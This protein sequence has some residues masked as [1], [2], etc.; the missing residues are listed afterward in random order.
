MARVDVAAVIIVVVVVVV[1]VAVVIIVC[2]C[3]GRGVASRI[4][5][6]PLLFIHPWNG[7]A[8]HT[9]SQVVVQSELG[10][11]T[12]TVG[13]C[14]YAELYKRMESCI[15]LLHPPTHRHSTARCLSSLL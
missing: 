4:A 6:Q 8:C 7:I 15:H 14:V 12:G 13:R 10:K 1:V 2:V 5:T 9:L 3:F 11:S